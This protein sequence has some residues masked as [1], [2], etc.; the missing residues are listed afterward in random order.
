MS[1]FFCTFADIFKSGT[2]TEALTTM[3]T[4]KIIQALTYF[5]YKQPNHELNNRKAYKLLWLADRYQLRQSGRFLTGD[6]Y[7]AM[8]FGPV[9]SDAKNILEGK[10]TVM[11]TDPEYVAQYIKLNGTKYSALCEPDMKVFSISDKAILDLV[12]EHFNGMSTAALSEM[13]HEFPEW[14]A[15]KEQINDKSKHSAYPIDIDYFFEESKN[16]NNSFFADDATA[17]GLAKELYHERNRA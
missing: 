16:P 4:R 8:Q 17:L 3:D 9:P 12:L 14:L 5:S 13:S 7:Y 6:K 10:D 2:V 11:H 1:F 15:Y